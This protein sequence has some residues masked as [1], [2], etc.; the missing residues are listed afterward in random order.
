MK[1]ITSK[2][3][4]LI[5]SGGIAAYKI[6]DLIRNLKKKD[7]EIKTILTNSAKEFVTSLS[8]SSLSKNKVY[9]NKFDIK[10]EVEMDHI[11][12]S[13]W[14]DVI[15]VAPATANLLSRIAHG[16]ADDFISTVISASNKDI[17]LAPAMNVE[18]WENNATQ[19]NIKKLIN[20]N[21]KFIGPATGELACGEIGKGKMSSINEVEKTLDQYF[22]GKNN[23]FSKIKVIVTAGPTRE[24]LDPIRYISNESSGK[25]GLEIA[26]KLLESGFDTTLITGP[27]N[28]TYPKKLKII[29]VVSA[30]E[31]MENCQKELPSDIAICTAAVSD[32]YPTFQKEK[33]KKDSLKN[34]YNL[35]INKNIDILEYLS[36]HSHHR[37]K[38]VIGFAAE[39]NNILENSLKKLRNKKCDWII[40]NDISNK[41][42]GFNSDDN[43]VTIIYKD[44]Q[45]EKISKTTK[46]EIAAE[47]VIR[48]INKFEM[49]N[50]KNFN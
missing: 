30:K 34:Q 7:Y 17:F 23:F 27:T 50:A 44:Q 46:S 5:I 39:T 6:L 26:K 48:I 20:F 21:F 32:F 18:M 41:K 28:L 13:R 33:I 22:F 12:L 45:I 14:S 36:N 47:I 24:Y 4:L 29:K 9:E 40:A 42:I 31:M 16:T 43:E 1:K 3:I 49:N 2:K 35:Q 37:P 8:I 11:A 10:N 15:L 19:E 25:Q 38:L